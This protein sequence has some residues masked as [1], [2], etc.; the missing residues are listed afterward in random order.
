MLNPFTLLNNF[1]MSTLE[2]RMFQRLAGYKAIQEESF[3]HGPLL[4]S[5]SHSLDNPRKE[6]ITIYKMGI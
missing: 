1:K 5:T 6:N 3:F 2:G 4:D